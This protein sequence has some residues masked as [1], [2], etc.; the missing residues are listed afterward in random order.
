VAL[1][2]I[3]KMM[4]WYAARNDDYVSVI[5]RGMHRHNGG[6]HKR[7]RILSD[8]EI[9]ALWTA[10]DGMGT[11]GALAKVALLTAQRR[12]V[13]ATMQWDDIADGVWRIPYE[14]RQKTNAGT[15]QLPK[16]VLDI[17]AAQPRIAG[18][19]DVFAGR[20]TGPF[21]SFSQR[22]DE[23]DAKLPKA[24]P[25]WVIHDL[26]RT[27]RSLLARAGV[28]PDIAERVLGHVIAGVEGVYDRHS[29]DA[30]KADA[31]NR[32]AALVESIINP[33]KGNVV[34]LT[35]AAPKR[36][37]KASGRRS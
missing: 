12:E 27:A 8:D 19:P 28:R 35:D 3:R 29:Y 7:K 24:T 6:D 1:A 33:P 16:A 15:L 34:A 22:K 30:E 20:G 23:L 2:I 37:R 17:I 5:V 9:R 21:N 32:L 13:V 18:N 31:L 26:R 11:F 25:P 10:C 4:N 36:P 14:A